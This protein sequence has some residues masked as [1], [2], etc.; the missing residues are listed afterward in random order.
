MGFSIN[1]S[2]GSVASQVSDLTQG[3]AQNQTAPT[4][5]SATDSLQQA[6][7]Q[8]MG[9]QM[10]MQMLQ[11]MSQMQQMQQQSQQTFD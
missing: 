10:I 11:E 3:S 5:T 2:L 6:F 4:G 8:G 9:Q 1:G 7:V